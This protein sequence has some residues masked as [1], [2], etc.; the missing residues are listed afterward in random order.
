MKRF[1]LMVGA[2]ILS[3]SM[4]YAATPEAY[5]INL[6]DGDTVMNEQVLVQFGL[7]GMGIA[8]A[9]I[10]A[11]N[12]GHH[13]ILLDREPWGQG[14]DDADMMEYGLYADENHIHYGKGQTEA[15][16]DLAPGQHTLQL[17]L[18]DYTHVPIKGLASDRIT[19]NVK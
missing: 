14:A 18:G 4:A 6:H 16:L 15:V 12:T 7:K 19:I 1:V 8:P 3:A 9:G 13:H 11:P 17:V 2:G 10:E 5:I